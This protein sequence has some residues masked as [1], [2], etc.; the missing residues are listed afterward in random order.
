M[1]C[2]PETDPCGS[3]QRSGDS[4]PHFPAQGLVQEQTERDTH[5]LATEVPSSP[6]WLDP[7]GSYLPPPTPGLFPALALSKTNHSKRL[8]FLPDILAPRTGVL[9]L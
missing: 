9:A 5:S 4:Y 1:T 2:K 7:K 6:N 3:G 8:L